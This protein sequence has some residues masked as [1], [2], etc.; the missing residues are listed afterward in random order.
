MRAVQL[1]RW[2]RQ[3]YDKMIEAGIFRPD[4]RVELIEG[5]IV[6][7]SPQDPAHSVGIRLAEEALRRAFPSGFD[8]RTQLPLA[9]DDSE[10]EPDVAVVLGSI[11]DYLASHPATAVLVVEV[12]DSSLDFDRR[13]KGRMYARHGIPEYWIVNLLDR[14]VEVYREP[15]PEGSYSVVRRFTEADSLTPLKSPDLRIPVSTLLP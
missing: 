2:S 4:E 9:L 13:R 15:R 3:E 12:A 1:R 14:V 5:E 6:E 11:R 8:V 10:P 7:M